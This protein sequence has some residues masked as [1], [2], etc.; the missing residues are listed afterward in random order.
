MQHLFTSSQPSAS[1]ADRARPVKP[2]QARPARYTTTT[3][4]HDRRPCNILTRSWHLHNTECEA[5][6]GVGS[7][8][9][10]EAEAKSSPRIRYG[11]Q[12]R[13]SIS[14]I[15]SI[16]TLHYTTNITDTKRDKFLVKKKAFFIGPFYL[17]RKKSS[18]LY[19]AG[20]S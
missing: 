12:C 17:P 11:C 8:T 10:F 15:V 6:T 13:L 19:L 20:C 18:Y 7:S 2:L 16:Q 9:A 5:S 1:R 3:T 4:P 14:S